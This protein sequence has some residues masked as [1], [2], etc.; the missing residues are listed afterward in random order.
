MKFPE[1]VA[2]VFVVLLIG[3]SL[4]TLIAIGITYAAYKPA[5][6]MVIVTL[7]EVPLTIETKC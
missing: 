5:F 6:L 4:F 2:V 1:L 3:F 7:D